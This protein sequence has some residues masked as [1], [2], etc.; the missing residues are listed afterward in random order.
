VQ[1]RVNTYN[2]LQ[3]AYIELI[4]LDFSSAK[5]DSNK[6]INFT[7]DKHI[8]S[9]KVHVTAVKEKALKIV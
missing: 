7:L 1:A 3:L 9:I 8:A 2:N 6:I 4:N 5:L